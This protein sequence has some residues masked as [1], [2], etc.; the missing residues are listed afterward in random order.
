M[1]S[2][3][4]RYPLKPLAQFL[5]NLLRPLYD[6]KS[7]A[8][9]LSNGGDLMERLVNYNES[10]LMSR[11]QFVTIKIRDFYNMLPHDDV[12]A[13]LGGFLSKVVNG[14]RY[15]GLSFETI[16]QLTNLFLHNNVFT[17][18][19][20]IYRYCKG[21]PLSFPLTRLLG[22][23]YL[24]DWQTSLI[25]ELR[26]N[27]ELFGRYHDAIIMTWNAPIERVRPLLEA[28]D[29]KH[30][31]IRIITTMGY[32]VDFLGVHIENRKGTLYTRVHH[33]PSSPRF[34]LPY[35]IHHPRLFYRQWSQWALTRAIR[36]CTSVND[37]DR[38][39]LYIELTLLTHGYSLDFVQSMLTTFYVKHFATALQQ[40]LDRTVYGTLRRRLIRTSDLEEQQRRQQ[41]KWK[42][43]NQLIHL[44]YLYDWGS[45]CQFNAK[46]KQLWS[47][48]I[49]KDSTLSKYGLKLK[50][51]SIHC[52]TLNSLL[53]QAI[54]S[55]RN[56]P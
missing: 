41:L 37:F 40:Y 49:E 35:V 32:S 39:R 9:S 28:L 55:R 2:S 33:D 51:S 24:Y 15:N 4:N 43:T 45:R 26:Y 10:N 31:D 5:D 47:D 48:L 56:A 23:I 38:E 20:H 53:T 54:P 18:N 21:A 44:H 34:L 27:E 8:T 50:L 14:G 17:Y 3:C 1:M 29:Q 13:A 22:N 7:Q 11:T 12:S 19:G 52:Y 42:S 6:S 46:F 16:Q 36:S 25:G 30:P